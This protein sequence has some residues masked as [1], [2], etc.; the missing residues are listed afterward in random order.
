MINDLGE[1]LKTIDAFQIGANVSNINQAENDMRIILEDVISRET[2]LPPRVRSVL[3]SNIISVQ[4]EID[5]RK[6]ISIGFNREQVHRA[7]LYEQGY[8]EGADIDV[9]YNNGWHAKNYVYGR[10]TEGFPIKSKKEFD[11]TDFIRQAIEECA[12]QLGID[13]KYFYMN[14]IYDF[15]APYHKPT[16]GIGNYIEG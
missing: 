15:D 14:D 4:E 7:S 11:I 8:P 16:Y 5:G 6:A 13:R 12:K 2:S 10:N 3:I 1:Y 9:L